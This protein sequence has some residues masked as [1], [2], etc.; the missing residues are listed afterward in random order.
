MDSRAIVRRFVR[1]RQILSRLDHPGIARLLDGGS[2]A[3]GRP[4]FVLERVEGVPITDYCRRAQALG[5]EERLRL[6]Q[7]VCAAVDSAHRRLVVHRDLKPANILVTEDGSVKLLDFGIAKLLAGDED[8]RDA[9][10]SPSS[11][12]AS[13]PPPTPRRSRSW[14]SR[15]PR[16]PTST[17]W[18]CCSSS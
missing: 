6:F 8:G 15:S 12:P 10:R 11:T 5:L 7:S 9:H 14:A 2:A 16:R 4:F 1:E 13:S 17:P 3:D 18:G